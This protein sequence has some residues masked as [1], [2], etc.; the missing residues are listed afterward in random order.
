MEGLG[1]VSHND[2][3]ELDLLSYWRIVRSRETVVLHIILPS[4]VREV[5]HLNQAETSVLPHP[6]FQYA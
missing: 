5:E 4:R 3:H 2:L 6:I 1:F